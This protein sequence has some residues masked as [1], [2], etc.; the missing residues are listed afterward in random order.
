MLLL[1]EHHPSLHWLVTGPDEAG[2]ADH[3]RSVAGRLGE[4]LHFQG[5][6]REPQAYM[7]AADV[8]CLP[9]Y[10]EGFN[11][12]VLE[13]A[14]VGIPTVASRIYG[15]TDAIEDGVSGL[16]VPPADAPAL[17][18]ALQR[19]LNDAQ[20]RRIMGQAARERALE[21]FSRERIVEGLA[22]FY[23]RLFGKAD[24]A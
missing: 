15:L 19:L 1:D 2:M 21:L 16:L 11:N 22:A 12:S 10:R 7:A 14:A 4:R 5:F 9:S 8:F 13:A 3:I 17:A 24:P 6:T 18:A 20:A 23:R